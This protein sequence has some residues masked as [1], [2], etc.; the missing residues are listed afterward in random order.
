VE[1]KQSSQLRGSIGRRKVPR[2][3]HDAGSSTLIELE[4][5]IAYQD[6]T[7]ADLN[8]V[9]VSLN[10]HVSELARRLEAVER[11]IRNHVEVREMPLEPPPHY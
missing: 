1:P 9:V 2:M 10:R 6:K 4:M 5:K 7:I 3:N 11:T 8:D